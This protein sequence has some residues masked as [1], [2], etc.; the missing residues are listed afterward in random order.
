MPIILKIQAIGV[1][2]IL[3]VILNNVT[4]QNKHTDTAATASY[5]KGCLSYLSNSVYYGRKD[6]LATPYI[7]PSIGYYHKSGVYANA[8][9]SY[10]A[11]KESRIDLYTLEA[12][13]DFD[14]TS[15]FSGGIYAD[16][17]FYNQ[18]STNIQSDIKGTAGVNLSYD[19]GVLQLNT[20][21]DVMFANKTDITINAGLSHAFY[22]GEE[23]NQWAI[24]PSATANMSTLN[25]YE[26]YTNRRVGKNSQ[27]QN[28]ATVS[29]NTIITNRGTG[30]TLLA[31]ELSMPISYDAKTW[32]FAITPTMALPQNPINTSTTSTLTPRV[33]T[34]ITQTRNSTPASEKQLSSVFYVEASVYI[35]F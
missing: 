4:A 8:S 25:F 28:G 21:A 34:P 14:I 16:K 33:G 9:L 29:S 12:G 27:L 2:L 19:F 22:L 20:S 10:L 26:G 6:S 3:F 31:Y 1:C 24:S 17:Y 18:A 30:L 32:G 15:K 23:D 13:Y 5:F 7:T 35:K 11:S